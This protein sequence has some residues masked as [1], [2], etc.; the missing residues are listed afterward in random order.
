MERGEMSIRSWYRSRVRNSRL[1]RA[2]ARSTGAGVALR[3]FIYL[4]DVSVYSLLASR[5]GPI[6]TEF[7]ETQAR[8]LNS[9]ISAEISANAGFAQGRGG[10]SIA[11]TRSQESQVI[12]KSIVQTAFKEL[13]DLDVT[14]LR[15]PPE[16]S[17]PP[18]ASVFDQLLAAEHGSEPW[19]VRPGSLRRGLLVEAEIELESEA[20][21]QVNVVVSTLLQI[22]DENRQLFGNVDQDGMLNMRAIARM[23]ETLLAGLVPIRCRLVEYV[24]VATD[25]GDVL[26]HNAFAEAARHAGLDVRPVFITGVT[27]QRLYWKDIR[28]VLFAGSTFRIFCRLAGEGLKPEWKPVKLADALRDVHPVLG[29]QL[30]NIGSLMLSAMGEAIALGAGEGADRTGGGMRVARAYVAQ[31]CDHHGRGP[32]AEAVMSQIDMT[33]AE[34]PGW[35]GSVDSW[36]PVFGALTDAVDAALGVQTDAGDAATLRVSAQLEGGATLPGLG[37][38]DAPSPAAGVVRPDE[39]Y[40]DTEVIAIYW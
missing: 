2:A 40:L 18:A 17:T 19:I 16:N 31:L 5:L 9:E 30:D 28:R 24:A 12:R 10:A 4:D 8:S 29:A 25:G 39:R 36:R 1:K 27:E 37:S 6:A 13:H 3:E 22:L 34:V 32:D 38:R 20:V 26:V 14:S 15:L 23:L 33:V 35:L 21:F 7:T 11:S